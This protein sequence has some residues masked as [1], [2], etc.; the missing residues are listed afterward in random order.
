MKKTN[1]IR[2]KSKVRAKIFGTVERPR[3]SVFRSNVFIYAQIIDD[4]KGV[5]LVSSKGARKDSQ[6]VG[7]EIAKR[8]VGKKINKV[9]FDKSGYKYHGSVKAL[10]EAVR[11]GGLEF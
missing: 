8:A 2:R 9:V 1:F 11:K 6:K 3:L 4:S 7:E 5:T 10:A